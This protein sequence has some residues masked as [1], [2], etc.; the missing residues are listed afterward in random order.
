MVVQACAGEDADGVG[1]DGALLG[2][3]Q[4]VAVDHAGSIDLT[5]H[6]CVDG[7]AFTAD[8]IAVFGDHHVEATD[9][10]RRA[11]IQPEIRQVRER[12]QGRL[13]GIDR[14]RAHRPTGELGD[15]GDV[16]VGTHEHDRGQVLIGVTHRHGGRQAARSGREP[17]C[18][19]PGER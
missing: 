12:Q 10:E 1:F 4:L 17:A 15:V 6:E 14:S 19:H 13:R 7:V 11:R 2:E 9:V 18:A 8:V 5:S 3:Q 16:A